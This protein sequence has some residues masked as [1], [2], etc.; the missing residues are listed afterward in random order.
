MSIA[1]ADI[2]NDLILELYITQITIGEGAGFARN[3]IQ[4]IEVCDMYSDQ[5][6]S[7]CLI[8]MTL[9]E[10]VS[11]SH[12][13]NDI[14]VCS[15][16]ENPLVKEDC[17][18]LHV[19]WTAQTTRDDSYCD[20]LPAHR[21]DISVICED[22]FA[23]HIQ[24]PDSVLA[25]AIPQFIENNVLL[26]LNADGT[27]SELAEDLGINISGWSWNS[28][29]ADVD[30]DSWQDL[31]V[32]NGR[33]SSRRRES[34]FFFVNRQGAKFENLTEDS[35]LTERRATG[36][37]SYVDIDGDG[38]LDI[39]S[40]PVHGDLKIFINNSTRFNSI[41]FSLLDGSGNSYGIGS[42][43]RITGSEGETRQMR[44]IQSGGGFRSF[45]PPVAHFGIGE[46]TEISQVE[47]LWSTGE[48]S[49]ID[50]PLQSGRH[51]HILRDIVDTDPLSIVFNETGAGRR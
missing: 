21:P 27:Y 14:R 36:A 32:A 1:N 2:D 13:R 44:E 18:A 15:S 22:M 8:E 47:I 39:I 45:D 43:V 23:E 6:R 4:S 7:D 42:K 33:V 11:T 17:V 41:R 49:V 38:D 46:Q 26:S 29:F 28:K 35:G 50:G 20:L 31:Y 37:Y 5:Q 40:V 30:N 51:Y 34:N 25:E 9:N 16:I 19:L 24:A 12:D 10:A 3:M 48:K